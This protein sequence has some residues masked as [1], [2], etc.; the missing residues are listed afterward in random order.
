MSQGRNPWSDLG[1][2][3]A[4]QLA[5]RYYL[6]AVRDAADD[7][8]R[9]GM[10]WAA[11]L[12]GIAFGNAG[13]HLP[14]AMSYAVSGLVHA[15]RMPGYP[16]GEPLVPHGVSVAVSAPSVFR[17]IAPTSPAR[18]LDAAAW[19]GADVRGAAPEDAGEA[20]AAHLAAMMRG[21]GLPNGLSGVGYGEADLPAL[22]AGTIVQARLVDNAPRPVTE[23]DLAALF[24]GALT[25][26]G[27]A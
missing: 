18:H 23:D 15:F 26:W 12:A 1:C 13:V 11:T 22:A 10:A 24:R 2:R 21:A 4:L 27:P 3:E 14:H 17:A 6:R 5:G 16:D 19:L 20:L 9:E 25:C 8:A 7:E